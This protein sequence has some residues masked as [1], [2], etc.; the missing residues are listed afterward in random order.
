M[1]WK[2]DLFL[3]LGLVAG[4]FFGIWHW[5]IPV[6]AAEPVDSGKKTGQRMWVTDEE[7]PDID[8]TEIQDYL[9]QIGGD[10][11]VDIPGNDGQDQRR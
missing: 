2:R 1:R 9:D 3:L 4:I 10:Q 7:E 8:L 6:L 5:K 11:T